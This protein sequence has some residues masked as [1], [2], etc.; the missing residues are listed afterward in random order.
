VVV[1]DFNVT[2]IAA[3][4]A[5]ANPPLIVYANAV[6]PCAITM[7]LLQTIAGRQTQFVQPQRRINVAELSEH[8]ASEL[9][10]K[11]PNWLALP[12]SL[13]IAVSEAANH[14]E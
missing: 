10:R 9:R 2:G 14:F 1:N 11:G 6:L 4:P 13:S 5:K 12:Q 7:Q 3:D 8:H